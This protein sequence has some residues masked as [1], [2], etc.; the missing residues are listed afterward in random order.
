MLDIDAARIGAVEIADQFLVGRG[1]AK[2]IHRQEVKQGLRLVF[3][4]AGRE[5][6]GVFQ[7]L[8]RVHHTPPHQSSFLALLASGSAMPRLI[9]SRMPGIDSRYRVSW[10]ACQSSADTS[11]ASPRL[12]VI[13]IG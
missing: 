5:L 3:Q 1:S 12:P 8:L 13:R 9:D 4:T 7:C 11:T 2:R 6:P 10:I